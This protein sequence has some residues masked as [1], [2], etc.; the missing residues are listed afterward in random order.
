RRRIAAIRRGAD[1][2]PGR[3]RARRDGLPRQRPAGKRTEPGRVAAAGHPLGPDLRT[4]VGLPDPWRPRMSAQ[5]ATPDSND[6]TL[7]DFSGQ[8]FLPWLQRASY[9]LARAEQVLAGVFVGLV[10]LLLILNIS[11][12]AFGNALY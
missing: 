11:T 12:R 2:V 10:F 9:R 3:C 5:T 7:P 6:V 1:L 4:H 8:G